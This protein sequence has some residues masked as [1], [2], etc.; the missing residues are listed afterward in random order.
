M[1]EE[2]IRKDLEG[3][4]A[5]LLAEKNDLLHKLDSEKG[6]YS[7]L[8]DK[9]AKTA[10]QKAD[11]EANL[12]DTQERLQTLHADLD[13]M[14]N[15]A[16]NSEEKAKKAMVDAARLAD[17]LRAE[18]EHAQHQEKLR[19][20]LESHV[21]ELQ[22]RVDEAE[23]AALKGGKKTIAK[24]ETRVRELEGELDGEQR[25]HA[26]AQKNLRKSERRIK[27]LTFQA[28]EDR[29]NHERMQDLVDKLQQKIKTY[30]R[31]IE[32]AE[33]IAALNLA[34][35]R[36]AQQELEATEERC[37]MADAGLGALRASSI[38]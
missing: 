3:V 6:G 35:F 4:N 38:F 8:L 24:L 30:K 21:K 12:S 19:K 33:E 14:L 1:G 37:K 36:K 2:K 10:A 27:E 5:T 9:Q 16:K 32:E 34:K 17:E 22:V 31:Q 26:E 28:E 25:R 7:D 23:A 29:K 15:E 11:L 20:E 13:E 18:Q